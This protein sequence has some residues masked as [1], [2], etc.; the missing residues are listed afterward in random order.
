[1]C[2]ALLHKAH[3]SLANSVTSVGPISALVVYSSNGEERVADE[4]VLE[5]AS[6]HRKCLYASLSNVPFSLRYC[7]R[8]T[9]A[10][11]CV[12]YIIKYTNILRMHLKYREKIFPLQV[13]FI[14]L[15]S[16]KMPHFGSVWNYEALSYKHSIPDEVIGFLNWC[17][18]S[19]GIL[20]LGSTQPLTEMSTRNF[21][22]GYGCPARKADDLTAIC[23][24][25][26]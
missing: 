20:T 4:L 5:F 17:N 16:E 1:V 14:L 25:I 10:Y 24:P 22:W 12:C 11:S 9:S 19:N 13:I 23:E 6:D 7:L 18:P 21:T 26:I 2:N 3:S 15:F 8:G